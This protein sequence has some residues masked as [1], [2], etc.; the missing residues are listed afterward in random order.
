[1]KIMYILTDYFFCQS[2]FDEIRRGFLEPGHLYFFLFIGLFFV[3]AVGIGILIAYKIFKKK[4]KTKFYESEIK[5]FENKCYE[6]NLSNKEINLLKHG[7]RLCNISQPQTIFDNKPRFNSILDKV[8]QF[9]EKNY[10]IQSKEYIQANEL[11]KHVI[12]QF[13]YEKPGNIDNLKNSK[14]LRRGQKIIIFH[15]SFTSKKPIMGNI[16]YLDDFFFIGVFYNASDVLDSIQPNS[17]IDVSF[18]RESDAN[19]FFSSKVLKIEMKQSQK[20]YSHIIIFQH[21]DKLYR[22]QKRKY[23]RLTISKPVIL[24]NDL[25]NLNDNSSTN[26]SLTALMIDISEGGTCVEFDKPMEIGAVI[27]LDFTLV[28]EYKNI[29]AVVVSCNKKRDSF[30]LHL[31]FIDL[32][33]E[34][35]ENIRKYVLT[36]TKTNF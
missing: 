34:L 15:R 17:K 1:M 25:L 3:L 12:K 11:I 21:S 19:Y 20:G 36:R 27:K 30:Y 35:K 28:I 5:I 9:Y 14:D 22:T 23:P 32:Q 18:N 7:M 24:N 10:T 33:F 26:T 16:I 8:L 29:N 13:D 2:T 6:K 4:Q 31:K